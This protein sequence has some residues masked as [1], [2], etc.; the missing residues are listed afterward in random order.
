M[1]GW[2]KKVEKSLGVPSR[3]RGDDSE[4]NRC[5]SSRRKAR[6]NGKFQYS[7]QRAAMGT[8]VG[9]KNAFLDLTGKEMRKKGINSVSKRRTRARRPDD[10]GSLERSSRVWLRLGEGDLIASRSSLNFER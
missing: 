5:S 1:P 6:G 8:F 7:N 9:G 3:E 4:C 2:E 10:A